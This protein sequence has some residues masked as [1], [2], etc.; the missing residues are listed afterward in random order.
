L[1]PSK[2]QRICGR[3]GVTGASFPPSIVIFPR[4]LYSTIPI[5]SHTSTRTRARTHT[6]T[7]N[8]S[9]TDSTY[10]LPL[11]TSINKTCKHRS[12]CWNRH[13]RRKRLPTS[14]GKIFCQQ[15]VGHWSCG[16]LLSVHKLKKKLQMAARYV[17]I[18]G[19]TRGYFSGS[20]DQTRKK[21]KKMETILHIFIYIFSRENSL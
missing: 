10:Y 16:V 6:H 20:K 8:F 5:H 2:S 9:A 19:F 17:Y 15:M 13:R 11:I 14:Y 12:Y 4:E 3:K 7:F 1:I 21:K 18:Q